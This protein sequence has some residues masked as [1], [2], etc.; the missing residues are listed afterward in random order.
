MKI[1]IVPASLSHYEELLKL[2]KKTEGVKVRKD[3]DYEGYCRLITKNEETSFVALAN[4]RIIG[5]ILCGID[6]K[7]AYIYHMMVDREFRHQKIGTKLVNKVMNKAYEM[8]IDKC[9]FVVFKD[10]QTGEEFWESVG[11]VKRTDLDY[12]DLD[13]CKVDML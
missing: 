3:D 8:K 4:D 1:E 5:S 9:S 10:N 13:T 7:R 12:Y 6:G 2:W 11:A